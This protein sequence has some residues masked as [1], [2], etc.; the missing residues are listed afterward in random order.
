VG[1]SALARGLAKLAGIPFAVAEQGIDAIAA[2]D[3][4]VELRDAA[5]ASMRL[6]PAAWKVA[7]ED[8]DQRWFTP[9]AG[10]L[11]KGRIR[12]LVIETVAN[13]RSH[14][15][16]VSRR[17]LWRLWRPAVALSAPIRRP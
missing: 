3:V 15:W 14:R 17:N 10:M 6:D 2:D 12:Q 16:S 13:G 7:L 5:T 8:L 1:S 9:L 11:K 4:L